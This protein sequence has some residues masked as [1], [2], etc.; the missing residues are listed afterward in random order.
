MLIC[1]RYWPQINSQ[2]PET[3]RSMEFF[4]RLGPFWTVGILLNLTLTVLVAWWVIRA[5][6]PRDPDGK[7]HLRSGEDPRQDG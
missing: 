4:A 7:S 6:R 2:R 5:M 1:P 3:E